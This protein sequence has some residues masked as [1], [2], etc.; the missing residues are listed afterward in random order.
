MAKSFFEQV[1]LTASSLALADNGAADRVTFS[2]LFAVSLSAVGERGHP[3]LDSL[4]R[5]R[6]MFK[7]TDYI[8]K[9][10]PIV[11]RRRWRRRSANR[12]WA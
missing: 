2:A 4:Q 8:M 10:A 9:M 12:V 1:V 5:R 11:S 6:T 3:V 7:M